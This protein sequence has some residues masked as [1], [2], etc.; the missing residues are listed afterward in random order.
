MRVLLTGATGFIG[1]RLALL[2]HAERVAFVATGALNTAAESQRQQQL[3][4]AG[5]P[6]ICGSLRDAAF[7][8]SL[9]D[10]FTHVIH[11][12]A[13]QHESAV[14][15]SWFMEHNVDLTRHLL[16]AAVRWKADA[17]IYGST[18]GV[19]G[20]SG[21]QALTEEHP[22]AP[23][24]AY[25]RSKVAAEALIA[26][27]G[28]QLHTVVLRIGETYGPGDLRLLKLF[29]A[30]RRG[31]FFLVGSG[32]NLHQPLY[33]ADACEAIRRVLVSAATCSGIYNLAGDQ[34][35]TTS[36]M[37]NAVAAAIGK[38]GKFPV[39]PM[40]LMLGVA[41]CLEWICTPL[42]IAPPLHRRRLDFFRRSLVLSNNRLH[43]AT[44]FRAQTDFA[45][46]ARSLATWYREAGLL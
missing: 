4:R 10:G 25:E 23:G 43:T 34:V 16:D 45:A 27:Y 32:S 21:A 24:N 36:D 13:A 39:V 38:P 46:G 2:L 7:R 42:R 40:S 17:F 19:Y 22:L 6:I 3:E 15:D 1:S 11:L 18:I 30:I 44:G 26:G 14:P 28:S 35:V 37:A 20:R 33:I 5:V 31:Q 8:A 9:G 12:A 29:H 41:L